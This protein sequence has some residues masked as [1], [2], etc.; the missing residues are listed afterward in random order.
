MFQEEITSLQCTIK[1]GVV[2]RLLDRSW[3]HWIGTKGL[4]ITSSWACLFTWKMG[5]SR[6][7]KRYPC[8]T[9]VQITGVRGSVGPH[10]DCVLITVFYYSY[11]QRRDTLLVPLPEI[12]SYDLGSSKSDGKSQRLKKELQFESKCHLLE[13]QE[14]LMLQMKSEGSLL[15]EIL[16][17][18][19]RSDSCSI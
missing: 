16:P 2:G 1:C 11:W 10:Y 3:T 7:C 5:W 6:C 12:D 14:E 19:R 4:S 17:A 15:A 13:N 18:W 9:P 8:V